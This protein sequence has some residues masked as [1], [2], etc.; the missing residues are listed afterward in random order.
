MREKLLTEDVKINVCADH[1]AEGTTAITG[2]TIDMRDFDGCVFM[3]AFGVANANNY[4][5]IQQGEEPGM[6]DAADLEGTKIVPS[7]NNELVATDVYRPTDRYLRAMVT[8]GASTLVSPI[9]AIQYKG[10]KSPITNDDA[11]EVQVEE[12]VSPN[13]GT[14]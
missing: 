10:R 8:R 12:F 13:E 4:M 5:K 1:T 7:G 3:A 6:S 14:A 2:A 9:L 11:G